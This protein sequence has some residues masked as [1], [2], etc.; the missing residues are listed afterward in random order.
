MSLL[1]LLLQT[2][3]L[4]HSRPSLRKKIWCEILPTAFYWASMRSKY[5]EKASSLYFIAAASG[6]SASLIPR[7]TMMM[8]APRSRTAARGVTYCKI[9][10]EG[11][12]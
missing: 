11:L 9:F 8:S 3:F 7:P 1:L 2:P 4:K 10:E 12:A 6:S 5:A